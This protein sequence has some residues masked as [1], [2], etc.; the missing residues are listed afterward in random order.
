VEANHQLG[1]SI[2]DAAGIPY[3]IEGPDGPLFANFPALHHTYLTRGDRAGIDLRT[4]QELADHSTPMLTAR[5]SHH[6]LHDLAGTV[7]R[8]PSFLPGHQNDSRCVWL[9]SVDGD[10]ERGSV[11]M[12]MKKPL[13]FQGFES[14]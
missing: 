12:D 5:Y 14:G 1:R 11:G 8:L 2:I 3:A 9:L 4:S 7:E 6:R 10:A 13:D